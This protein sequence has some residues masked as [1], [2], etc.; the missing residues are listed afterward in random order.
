M[1]VA[2]I[3]GFPNGRFTATR[4]EREPDVEDIAERFI[5]AGGMY[6]I[7][8]LPGG[9]VN[10]SAVTVN[11]DNSH[12]EVAEARCANGPE[13]PAAV[14]RLVRKSAEALVQ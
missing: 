4:I 10:M 5:K 13:L 11:P 3:R 8:I 2:F 9:D 14:D 1:S 7:E 12:T 6:F